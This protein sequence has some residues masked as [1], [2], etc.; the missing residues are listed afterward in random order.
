MR[1]FEISPLQPDLFSQGIG[2][3]NS[4]SLLL[5]IVSHHQLLCMFDCLLRTIMQLFQEGPL[6]LDCWKFGL[7]RTQCVQCGSEAHQEFEWGETSGRTGPGVVHVL[8]Q[9]EPSCPIVLLM[10][11]VNAQ[12][13]LQPLIHLLR[14]PISLGVVGHTYVS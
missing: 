6:F 5:L 11:G 3:E 1:E 4:F 2:S 7:Y 14:L 8:S 13:L 9:R 12:I 10:I